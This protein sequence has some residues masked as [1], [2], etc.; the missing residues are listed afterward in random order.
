MGGQ[1]GS[2]LVAGEVAEVNGEVAA[3]LAVVARGGV[4]EADVRV[5]EGGG[6]GAAGTE[7]E[8][9]EFV[10]G[11]VEEEVG[12]V[13]VGLHEAELGDL[14][15]AE[16]EDL[17]ADPVLLGLGEGGGGFGDAGAV[18]SLHSE[19]LGARGFGYDGWDDEDTLVVSE[20]ILESLAAFG[21][22]N[23]IAFPG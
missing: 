13:G 22:S 12:P 20:E 18:H 23:V 16:A 10:A 8:E 7:V 19:D 4:E 15:Q 2:G 11:R 5:D 17:G 6:E 3:G 1:H 21:F 14:A 9:L